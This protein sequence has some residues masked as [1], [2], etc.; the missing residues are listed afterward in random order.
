MLHEFARKG[1][2]SIAY[3]PL[4]SAMQLQLQDLHPQGRSQD[5]YGGGFFL[6]KYGLL[7]F[8]LCECL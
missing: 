2:R 8:I 5:F 7:R 1:A 3:Q 4:I 6:Q